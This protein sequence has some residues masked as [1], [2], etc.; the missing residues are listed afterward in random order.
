MSL[1]NGGIPLLGAV[2]LIALA[3]CAAT[4]GPGEPAGAVAASPAGEALAG[5]PE[6][7]ATAF[8]Q[9]F[10]APDLAEVAALP[11]DWP[12]PPDGATLCLTASGFGGAA[13][14]S[15]SYVVEG[16][17]ATIL[18]HY[19]Q[20]LAAYA[21]ERTPSP[22]GGEMLA[23]EGRGIGFQVQPGEGGFVIVIQPTG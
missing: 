8:P 23:G 18:E 9:A 22:T 20:A 4:D 1:R 2:L 21:V 17:E 16:D 12:E 3:G 19:E 13:T 7:C 5:A 6:E 15:I 11:A 10:T 14:E